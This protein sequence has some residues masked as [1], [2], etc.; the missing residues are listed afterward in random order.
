[1]SMEVIYI[2]RTGCGVC[3]AIRPRVHA[4]VERYEFCQL[5]EI[6]LDEEPEAAGRYEVFSLPAVLVFVDQQESIRE[7]RFF[8]MA[9]LEQRMDRLYALRFG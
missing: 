1:M 8:D 9:A 4:L 3:S 5:R 7:A 6:N 2:T